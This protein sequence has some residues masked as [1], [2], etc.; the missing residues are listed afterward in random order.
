[1]TTEYPDLRDLQAF[2]EGLMERNEDKRQRYLAWLGSCV[3]VIAILFWLALEIV[4]RSPGTWNL[5]PML[6]LASLLLIM[7]VAVDSILPSGLAGLFQ[8][9]M[10]AEMER[11]QAE[12]LTLMIDN[13]PVVREKVVFSQIRSVLSNVPLFALFIAERAAASVAAVAFLVAMLRSVLALGLMVLFLAIAHEDTLKMYRTSIEQAEQ[14]LSKSERLLLFFYKLAQFEKAASAGLKLVFYGI[15]VSAVSWLVLQFGPPWVALRLAFLSFGIGILARFAFFTW[16]QMT[17]LGEENTEWGGVRERILFGAVK[18]TDQAKTELRT[19]AGE[20]A[21]RRA[22][23]F[24][25]P[26]HG[27]LR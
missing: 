23:P 5:S 26:N 18:T 12:T 21:R 20:L 11:S 27:S 19:R 6:A 1:M 15:L 9:A 24:E 2:L 25:L 14:Q 8:K 17:W 16:E 13:L 7:F 4:E 3:T 10:N 22:F